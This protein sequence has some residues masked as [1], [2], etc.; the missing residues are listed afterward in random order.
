MLEEDIEL[1]VI[2]SRGVLQRLTQYVTSKYPDLLNGLMSKEIEKAIIQ[3]ID[4]KNTHAHTHSQKQQQE[5]EELESLKKEKGE[6]KKIC[7]TTYFDSISINN[8]SNNLQNKKYN[9]LIET[10]KHYSNE[11]KQITFGLIK[12]A[13]MQTFGRDPR[14]IN[15]YLNYLQEDD[16]LYINSTNGMYDIQSWVFGDYNRQYSTNNNNSSNSNK[17]SIQNKDEL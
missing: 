13:I 16:I 10:I 7:S 17:L 5:S 12:K 2:I 4:Y 8:N 1:K 14:T 11:Q 3:Y 6:T 15:K 9:A